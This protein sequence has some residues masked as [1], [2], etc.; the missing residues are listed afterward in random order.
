[1]HLPIY[2]KKQRE[3]K[4]NSKKLEEIKNKIYN[5][6]QKIKNKKKKLSEQENALAKKLVDI[7][8]KEKQK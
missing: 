2:E 5:D 3:V 8:N 4:M 1:M 6:L 7:E